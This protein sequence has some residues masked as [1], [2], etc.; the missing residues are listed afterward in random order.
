MP[1]ARSMYRLASGAVQHRPM[2]RAHLRRSTAA[3]HLAKSSH[4]GCSQAPYSEFARPKD[5]ASSAAEVRL[6][7]DHHAVLSGVKCRGRDRRIPCPANAACNEHCDPNVER[8]SQSF[9]STC[10][11]RSTMKSCENH[12]PCRA[13]VTIAREQL[14]QLLYNE[15]PH[16]TSPGSFARPD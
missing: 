16:H 3:G 15:A 7:T 11:S 1:N 5:R 10:K 12:H 4:D 13:F 8:L 2:L 9:T 14:R 6:R